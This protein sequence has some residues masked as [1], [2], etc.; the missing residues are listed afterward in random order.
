MISGVG[1]YT[2]ADPIGLRGGTNL[3]TYVLNNPAA[4]VD[5]LG[6][7]VQR[8][9]RDV[10][11]NKTID[12]IAQV[13]GFKH[14]FLRTDTLE[15]G[16]GPADNGPLPSCPAGVQTAVVRHTGQSDAPGTS[17]T[18][19]TGVDEGCVNRRLTTGTP[20]GRW[21]P[22]NNC[23]SFIDQVTQSC[24]TCPANYWADLVPGLG[25]K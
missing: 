7:K 12:R 23:N 20:T 2:Q 6:L 25:L 3:F 4:K 18:D 10:Q 11:V 17:C 14:C 22:W 8:C 24:Q 15:A 13:F 19:V 5:P 21:T 16:M 9:C 1:R